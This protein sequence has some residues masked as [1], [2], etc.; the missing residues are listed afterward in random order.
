MNTETMESEKIYRLETTIDKRAKIQ[1]TGFASPAAE[2]ASDRINLNS[3]LIKNSN[4]YIY[5]TKGDSM[6]DVGILP[7]AMIVFEQRLQYFSGDVCVVRLGDE[8]FIRELR[9]NGG[10]R[11]LHPANKANENY[12][13]VEVGE[14][15]DFEI[16]GAVTNAINSLRRAGT[17]VVE[18]P[19]IKSSDVQRLVA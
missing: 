10:V 8:L 1:V 3:S 2:F 4:T 7:G 6:I 12:K 16:C 5:C 9:V 18:A 17:N 15:L 13:P 14:F 19:K 11:Y